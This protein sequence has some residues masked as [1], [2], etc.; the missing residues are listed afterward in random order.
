[1]LPNRIRPGAGWHLVSNDQLIGQKCDA[2]VDTY[3]GGCVL[4]VRF[5]NKKL[6]VQVAMP[7]FLS[8]NHSVIQ[9][10]ETTSI[11]PTSASTSTLTAGPLVRIPEACSNYTEYDMSQA[12]DCIDA[13]ILESQGMKEL[14]A[15]EIGGVVSGTAA[16]LAGLY[17]VSSS[18]SVMIA[19]AGGAAAAPMAGARGL[20]IVIGGVLVIIASVVA[21]A[22]NTQ[23]PTTLDAY[24]ATDQQGFSEF[25]TKMS[26]EQQL[27]FIASSN[28]TLLMTVLNQIAL[29]LK[30]GRV[31]LLARN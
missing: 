23:Q 27:E 22:T 3:L 14:P 17:I 29:D 13:F 24:F 21:I 25:L 12:L 8:M 18:S 30:S 6:V 20:A 5:R 19:P 16:M 11:S 9:A 31:Q 4:P 7:L 10:N 28:P 26:R 15:F 1:M 2:I